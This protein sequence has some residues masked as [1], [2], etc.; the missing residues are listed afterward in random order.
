MI[1]DQG[2]DCWNHI[3][4]NHDIDLDCNDRMIDDDRIIRLSSILDICYK[5]ILIDV[6]LRNKVD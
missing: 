1:K 4:I 5:L 3:D 2:P 6:Q